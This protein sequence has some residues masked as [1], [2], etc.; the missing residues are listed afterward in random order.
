MHAVIER[1]SKHANIYTQMQWYTLTSTAKKNGL[2]YQVLEREGQMK[3]FESLGE[4]YC[5]QLQKAV[6]LKSPEWNKEKY[7]RAD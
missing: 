1:A 5:K 4:I 7:L 6:N 2:C 3:D